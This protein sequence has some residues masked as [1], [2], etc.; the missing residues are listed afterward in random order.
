MVQ[1]FKKKLYIPFELNLRTQITFYARFECGNLHR[2]VKRQ[3]RETKTFS[4]LTISDIEK[5]KNL[6][7]SDANYYDY[8]Y[9][10]YLEFD[11]NNNDGLMH[12]YYF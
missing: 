9:D 8:E 2:V 11:T 5:A 3:D 12:W 6:R 4:G 10:L 1:T 7:Q